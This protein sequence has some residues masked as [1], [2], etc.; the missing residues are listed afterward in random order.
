[1]KRIT[2]LLLLA[3]M[4]F[5]VFT[6]NPST[7]YAAG[8]AEN[9]PLNSIVIK[10]EDIV[11]HQMLGGARFEIYY[12]N[13]AVSGGYGTLVATVD[14]D[15]SGVIVISG[16][17]SGYYI[18]RQTV[19]PNN[20]HLTIKNEQN[21]YIKPDGTSVEELVFSNYRYGGLVVILNDKD[22]GKP[23]AGATFSVTDV[24]NKAVGNHADG[25]YTTTSNGEFF[26][27]NLPAGDYKVT[28]LTTAQGY[29]MDSSPSTRTL[30][31]QH[32]NADQSIFMAQFSNSPLGTLLVRLKDS[33][34]KEPLSGA[35]FNVKISGG[36][37]LG[38][39]TTGANGSFS[40]PKIAKGTYIITQIS[41][42][43]G[44]LLTGT[45]KTQYVDYINTYAVDFENQPKSGLYVTKYDK[46]TKAPLKDAKFQVYQNSTLIGTYT[47]NA[48]GVFFIPNLNPGWYTISE[49]AAPQGYILDDTPKSVQIIAET[50]HRIEFENSKLA[51]LQIIKTDEFNGD[52]L[53]GAKFRVTTQN[54]EFVADVTTDGSGKAVI[55]ALEPGWY[56]ISET[57]APNGYLITE[58]ARTVEVKSTVPTVVTITNRAENNLQIVK[59]DF[60]T[61][62]P[63]SGATFKVEHAN[64][65]N[66]GTFNTDS[67]GKILIGNLKE[68]AYVISE[69]KAPNGYQL[70]SEPQTVVIEGGK[71]HSVEFLDKP[72]TA[73]E[74][75]K[76]DSVTKLP[77]AGATF[78]VERPNG[79]V[80]GTYK[81]DA[82][83]K[84]IVSA[85]ESG[86]Y[87]VSE[88]VAP[89]GYIL[90][91][92][93][94]TVTVT[95]NKVTTVEFTNKPYSGIQII[96]TD[97]VTHDPLANATFR[98]NRP[99][100]ELI[101]TYKTDVSG[102]V[103][104]PDLTEGTYI[105]S[106]TIAPSGYV[107][108][109]TPK[110]VTV[111]SGK[112]TI[113]EFANDPY[114][115]L[116]IKKI[117][118]ITEQPLIGARFTVRH[119]GGDI[120]GENYTTGADGSVALSKLQ[121][122]WY[123]VSETRAPDGYQLDNTAKTIEVKSH[124]PTNVTFTNRP[125]SG[126][127]IIKT[128]SLTNAPLQGAVFTVQRSNGDK[129]GDKYTTDVAGKIL[130]PDL[131]EGTYIITE[132]QAPAEYIL[133]ALPQ[134]VEVKSGKLT[135]AEFVNTPFPYLHIVKTN[136][137][138]G[139]LVSGAEFTVTNAKGEIIA[140][141]VSQASGAVSLKVAPG[142]YTVTEVKAPAGFELNDPVQTVEVKA[143]GSTVY[144]GTSMI[145]PNNTASFAN[146][147]LNSIEIIKLDSVTH[148]P[149]S[150]AIFSI[151]KSNGE[152]IGTF[153]TDVAGLILISSLTE[154]TY[155]ISEIAAPTGYILNDSP[156]SVNVSGGRLVSETFLNKPLSGIQITKLDAITQK[157]LAGASFSVTKA[158]GENIGTFRTESDGKVIIPGLDEGV[159]VIGELS[160]PNGY[161]L[162]ETPKNVTVVSGRLATVEFFNKPHSG[163]Q[164][165][166]T[167]AVTHV[168]LANATF[169]V[170]R[171]NG[172][173]IGVYK[174]DAAGQILVPDLAE[175]TY[176]VSETA[177]PNGYMLDQT[178][179]TVTVVSGR[180]TAVE[181][182][183]APY[184]SLVIKKTDEITGRPLAG[185]YFT[186]KHQNGSSVGDF[187][188][189]NDGSIVVP[190]LEPGW[191]V[192]SETKAPNGYHLDT[193]AKTIEVKSHAPVTVTFT[194]R[195]YSGIEIIKTDAVSHAP[196]AGAT[197]SVERSNGEKIGIYKT[198]ISGK[199]IVSDLTEG[200]YIVS[201]IIAPDGYQLDET[202][203][204]ITVVSGRI[205]SV[206]FINRPYSGIEIIKTDSVTNAPLLGASFIVERSN[207]ERIGSYK[208][209]AAGKIIVS[210]L[211]E[212]TYIVSETAA[213]NGYK[214][215]DTPKTVTVKSGRLTTVEFANDPYGSLIIKKND[216]L[217]AR[218]L[219]GAHFTVKHQ[220]GSAVGD[221]ITDNDGA[222]NV[223]NLAPGWY[224]VSETKAPNGYHLDSAAKTIEVKTYAPTT[225]TFTNRAF[226]GIE[227]VKTD[228]VTHAPLASATF[229]VERS[230]GEKIGTYKTDAAGKIIVPELA[231]GTY[232]VS[233]TIAPDG[234]QLD[235]TPKT[236]TVVSGKMTSV[237][238]TNRPYSGIE[239]VKLDAIRFTPLAGATFVV[240][241]DNGEKIGT[242]RT[243]A[244][245]K[246]IVS[247][248]AEGT[249][250][251]SETIAPDGYVRDEAPK[252]V[253]VKSGK[254]TSVEFTNKP[255][256]GIE[257]IKIDAV[258]KSPLMG[259]TFTVERA[260]GEKIGTFKT[261][262]AGK[263]IIPNLTEGTYIV[264]ETIAP[265][266]Y[267]LDETPKT[268]IVTSG[269]LTSVEFTNKPHSGIQIIKLDAQTNAPLQ[270]ASFIVERVNG[271]RVGT[272]KTDRTGKIIVPDLTE[273]T[274]IISETE[275][276]DGYI[277]DEAPKTV[278]VKSGKITT[279]EFYN[280]QLSGLRIIKLDSVT[281]NPIA[282]VEFAINKMNGERVE[283][284]FRSYNFKTDRTG[285]I[286]IPDLEDGYYVV[287]ETRSADGYILDG[288]PK[289]VLVQSGKITVHEVFNTPMS[290]LLIVKTDS[291]TG[292]PIAGAVFDIKRADGSFVTGNILDGN[293][294]NTANN[295]QNQTTS[296][297]GNIT[298]SY[299]TDAN[300]RILINGLDAGQ[301]TVTERKA[302]DGY[303]LDT[304]VYNVTVV[305]G[306]LA[307]LQLQ[308]KP[309][310]GIR[311]TKVDSLTKKPIYNV[312][313][314]LFDAS[315]KVVGV[316]Y[317]DNN[318]RI[319]F[320][321]D[322]PAGR[323]TIRETRAANGYFLDDMPK[324]IEFVP[325]KVTEVTWEN[326]PQMGQIQILKKAGD[327]NEVNGLPAG[328]PLSG[329]VFEV[330]NQK[331][332]NLVDRFVSGNDGRAVSSPLPLGRYIV[333]EVQAPKYYKVSD[334]ELDI[335][336]EFA[337]EIAKQE[338]LNYSANTGVA[339]KKTGNVEA[340]P[341]DLI[342][343]DIKEVRNTGT[344]PLTDFFWRDV[345]PV[346]AVR[347]NKIVTGTYNQS[348]K[349]KILATTNKGNTI[350]I[351]DNLST[352]KNNVVD[353]SSASL[354]LRSDEFVTSFSLM[355]G[356]VKAGF[357]QV[358]TPQIYV[359]VLKTLPNG[360]KFANK[361]DCGGKYGGEWVIGNSTI[362]TTIYSNSKLPKTGY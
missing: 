73:I 295:S 321:N 267:Q 127:Q 177:A 360:Y 195:A 261:D 349:F 160:A 113:V 161:Q 359:D 48:D 193:A 204:T 117:C 11:T 281:R 279:V 37:D 24:N 1:M 351:A 92:T 336:I 55:P 290:G 69:I 110:T 190:N 229:T 347:L 26:L 355:F 260:N 340:M 362:T 64:G 263:I 286:Y 115:S 248:L 158:N 56:V 174:T 356:T 354:G 326:T 235:E 114:G 32:T 275:A 250:V 271:E 317:T 15:G 79:E 109:E 152:R 184:G 167:D 81:T 314:M 183:N 65:A 140:N 121:P 135:V 131:P 243:D 318:G 299:T 344:V 41:A 63:L 134:T 52:P 36:A 346:D 211:P 302:P 104:V 136:A 172:E 84:A 83:G 155:I 87:I 22:T 228:A 218:P 297:N 59:L 332:G 144:Y 251:V 300:G 165:T 217:T 105:V 201:E 103:I 138:T 237:E 18:V 94:K 137:S 10:I 293:Q 239:I 164:I 4:L 96:K 146:R 142:V 198:D 339:I 43:S 45:P 284:D 119:Q 133:D 54:G 197:F 5:S 199:I 182:T 151:D 175:G 156:K 266:G 122:G 123:V 143:D 66:V 207:G 255:L 210:D 277:L 166:K 2:S 163:I 253:I 169:V 157:P 44:Y 118:D 8:G 75:V 215:N 112:V 249:Y 274:Y 91:E 357:A 51:S 202:P 219:A 278:D 313:F 13:E 171:S 323:Y 232:I 28:Q 68:G 348:L 328:T 270:G 330:Y 76:T 70:D 257:V 14:S 311:L 162:D 242:Y 20:Y 90:H 352:T 40:L 303:E 72:L 100:G 186:V 189:D 343:Y 179:K 234:Y 244:T 222:I 17:P 39:F 141:V 209:D 322:I 291:V 240:E 292:K 208:T 252:T 223:P 206:E 212:G 29:A 116:V 34:S 196:L 124:V 80:I 294:P 6:V 187:T 238:F 334:R 361:V 128:N 111:V 145:Y 185:A 220:N 358:E 126:I 316:Y 30:R 246:I 148:N 307:T 62:T 58:A 188:T 12:S 106:E 33:I 341:G 280:K 191:Y 82:A 306:K 262:A 226:S 333:K 203:K 86:T 245:G 129:A 258:T 273:G 159:Y 289:T 200:A 353:C 93:P 21:C 120:V 296:G 230:N 67:A 7:A 337:T 77:L 108:N 350:I 338:F 181:F 61:R 50:L 312:E 3:V 272:Y 325:G 276:P 329:A 132:I 227:I 309:M 221:F 19:P 345:L 259:A 331:T 9:Y 31:L 268:V 335:T 95:S 147:P 285:Q 97:S 101:G 256:S 78:K 71:L 85:L 224:V 27:E 319:D 23:I 320:P 283:N 47:T 139:E 236:V 130:V 305:P 16:I 53:M 150:G 254:L 99:N 213:P 247:N 308:N 310:G 49:Y 288:E 57:K 170:E 269:K 180:I 42:T 216:E 88:T 74:I 327:D 205:A 301:Y 125:H 173:R 89:N 265:D 35:K 98:I 304:Q 178:P 342:R 38:E 231:E 149:L 233:E 264:S 25:I 194:N 176:I 324:T 107:L 315:N 154:G 287:T 298:G 168:P 46:D 282:G 102:K 241:R 153:R 60:F 214:L 192:V 225:I